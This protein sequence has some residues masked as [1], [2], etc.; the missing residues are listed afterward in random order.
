[1]E[2][3][4]IQIS[5][6]A[7]SYKREFIIGLILLYIYTQEYIQTDYEKTHVFYISIFN[8]DGIY[9]ANIYHL[10]Y[11]HGKTCGEY[12]ENTNYRQLRAVRL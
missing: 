5:R 3:S 10:Q 9:L 12:T 4:C 8:A 6:I 7:A 2:Q 11:Y 1:M